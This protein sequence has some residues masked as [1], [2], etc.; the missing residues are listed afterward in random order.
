[1]ACGRRA[2]T[3]WFSVLRLRWDSCGFQLLVDLAGALAGGGEFG[4]LGERLSEA[5]GSVV[6]LAAG[7]V[8]FSEGLVLVRFE[9][10]EPVFQ[11]GDQAGRVGF[12]E[13]ARGQSDLGAG[14]GVEGG[15]TLTWP[16]VRETVTVSGNPPSFPV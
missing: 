2:I 8:D 5:G 15:V 6:D 10:G 14:G 16:R 9:V 12:R 4:G 7:V 11:P 3:Q 1:V 13:I